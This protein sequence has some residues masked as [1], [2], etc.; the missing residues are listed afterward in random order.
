MS[1]PPVR[2]EFPLKQI[3]T[4]LANLY[5]RLQPKRSGAMA[6]SPPSTYEQDEAKT[7]KVL[8][9]D[10]IIA[11]D[12]LPITNTITR[13]WPLA[14]LNYPAFVRA[15]EPTPLPPLLQSPLLPLPQ[16]GSQAIRP[17]LN[18]DKGSS[19]AED[20]TEEMDALP[21]DNDET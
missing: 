18:N 13:R 3:G 4:A 2:K 20:E 16:Q 5:A 21:G 15:E 8:L 19:L 17:P 7:Q 9:T 6:A 14:K 12:D 11:L 1:E 10:T